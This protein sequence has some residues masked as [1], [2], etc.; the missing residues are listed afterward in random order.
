MPVV[1]SEVD[2]A[3]STLDS[4]DASLRLRYVAKTITKRQM[5]QERS[6]GKGAREGGQGTAYMWAKQII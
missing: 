3:F 5:E 6:R 2:S 1:T 4:D